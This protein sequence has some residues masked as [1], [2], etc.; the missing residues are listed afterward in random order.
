MPRIAPRV[1]SLGTETALDVLV[2]ARAVEARGRRV[3]HLEVGEPD[4]PTPPHIVEAG[5][6]ALREGK[7]RYGAPAGTQPLREAICEH[8]LE[9]DVRVFHARRSF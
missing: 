2:K 9:E 1:D 8:L 6:R 7:T 5:I 3:I 4:F